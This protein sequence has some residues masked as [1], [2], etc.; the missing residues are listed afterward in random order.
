VAAGTW[1]F[2]IE[3]GVTFDRTLTYTDADDD[4]VPMAGLKARMKIRDKNLDGA[5]VLELTTE[6]GRIILGDADG[7]IRLVVDSETTAALTFK[8]AVHDFEL[9][10]DTVAPA[11]EIVNRLFKGTATLSRE[12]TRD[13]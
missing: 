6:N 10:D 9:V 13:D 1:N 8:T 12:A 3:Q 7:T 2:T 5:V 11:P 4:P